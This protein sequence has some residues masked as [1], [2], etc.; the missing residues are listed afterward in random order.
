MTSSETTE[1]YEVSYN[2]LSHIF[3]LSIK[4]A[5]NVFEGEFKHFFIK[6]DE[7]S[8]IKYLKLDILSYIA[9]PSNI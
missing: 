5:N 1:S 9:S 6:Y 4:G 8:Y 3:L 7:P 2:I